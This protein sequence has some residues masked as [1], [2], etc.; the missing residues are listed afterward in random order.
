MSFLKCS[1]KGSG[2]TKSNQIISLTKGVHM[3][4]SF[5][6]SVKSAAVLMGIAGVLVF[7]GGA[8]AQTATAVATTTGLT[9]LRVGKPVGNAAK[10]TVQVSGDNGATPVVDF[11]FVDNI[12]TGD[13]TTNLGTVVPGLRLG[14][15]ALSQDKKKVDITIT[16]CPTTENANAGTLT[17]SVNSGKITAA[18]TPTVGATTATTTKAPYSAVMP[19]VAITENSGAATPTYGTATATTGVQYTLK[20]P[21]DLMVTGKPITLTIKDSP[22]PEGLNVYYAASGN[23]TSKNAAASFSGSGELI[24]FTT[25][26]K[27]PVLKDD[28]VTVTVGGQGMETATDVEVTLA[29]TPLAVSI[30][31]TTNKGITSVVGPDG[32]AGG[33]SYNGSVVYSGQTSE[34]NVFTWKQVAGL[35]AFE[36]GNDAKVVYYTTVTGGNPPSGGDDMVTDGSGADHNLPVNVA[37]EYHAFLEVTGYGNYANASVYLGKFAITKASPKVTW[38]TYNATVYDPKKQTL[39]DWDISTGDDGKDGDHINDAGSVTGVGDDGDLTGTFAWDNEDN[40]V[41]VGTT[42]YTAKWTPTTGDLGANNYKIAWNAKSGVSADANNVIDKT[43]GLTFKLSK[44]DLEVENIAVKGEW[45]TAEQASITQ[46]GV[47]DIWEGSAIW[48]TYNAAGQKVIFAWV[49]QEDDDDNT[50]AGAK[51]PAYQGARTGTTTKDTLVLTVGYTGTTLAGKSFGTATNPSTTAPTEAGVYTVWVK[52]GTSGNYNG[53]WVTGDDDEWTLVILPRLIEAKTIEHFKVYDATIDVL[54]PANVTLT[55]NTGGSTKNDKDKKVMGTTKLKAVVKDA[56]YSNI[57]AGTLEIN[58]FEVD[59]GNTNYQI[60]LEDKYE[61]PDG[62]IESSHDA[63]EDCITKYVERGTKAA[64][65]G[66]RQAPITIA[67]SG[68]T[69]IEKIFNGDSTADVAVGSEEEEGTAIAFDGLQGDDELVYGVDYE[70]T[71]P[72]Y[73]SKNVGEDIPV[74]SGRL[75]LYPNGT[76]ANLGHTAAWNYKFAKAADSALAGKGI[77]GTIVPRELGVSG[78]FE[79]AFGT[80]MKNGKQYTGSEIVL[81]DTVGKITKAELYVSDVPVTLN[82][83][84]GNK[85][86][87]I[88][89]ND[90]VLE[91]EDNLNVTKE[92]KVYIH[93]KEGGNYKDPELTEIEALEFEIVPR[94]LTLATKDHVV[95]RRYYHEGDKSVPI[96]SLNFVGLVAG[97]KLTLE[98]EDED[99]DYKLDGVE[100]ATADAS[101]D[102]KAV[103]RGTIELTSS[104]LAA[105]YVLDSKVK[106]SSAG[107]KGYVDKMPLR[108]T[109]VETGG[110]RVYNGSDSVNIVNI[111]FANVEQEDDEEFDIGSRNAS[112]GYTVSGAKYESAEVGTYSSIAAGTVALKGSSNV[113]N[114]IINDPSLAGKGDIDDEITQRNLSI[115]SATVS[116]AFD[117][118]ATINPDDVVLNFAS[119]SGDEGLITADKGKE[120]YVVEGAAFADEAIKSGKDIASGTITL[121]DYLARNYSLD[122]GD[123]ASFK[124]SITKG[125]IPFIVTHTKV[126]D[127]GVAAAGAEYTVDPGSHPLWVGDVMELLKPVTWTYVTKNAGETKVK[128]GAI[129][130]IATLPK[131][132][133]D[134][135]QFSQ[136]PVDM[137]TG[138]ITKKPLPI[139]TVTH[140]KSYDGTTDAKITNISF[141]SATN[142]GL[143]STDAASTVVADT[144]EAE[145]T[146]PSVGTTTVLIKKV[147]L[148]GTNG[149]NYQV[150]I[151]D[152]ALTVGGT[153][154]GI[155]GATATIAKVTATK[156]YD[157]TNILDPQYVEVSFNGIAAVDTPFVDYDVSGVTL[158]DKN[159]GTK[160]ISAGKVELINA[161]LENYIFPAASG[162][163]GGGRYTVTVAPKTLKILSAEHKKDYDGTTA[164]KNVKVELD[165]SGLVGTDTAANVTSVEAQY[166]SAALGTK[167][168]KITKITVAGGNYTADTA[169]I[170]LADGGITGTYVD[171][172]TVTSAVAGDSVNGRRSVQLTANVF[173]TTASIR[174]VAW[175]VSDTALATVNEKTGLL[176]SK[177]NGTVVVTAASTDGSGKKGTLTLKIYGVGVLEAEREIPTQVVISEAA[178]A[179][180]KAVVAKFTAGP[181]PAKVGSSIKFFSGSAVKSG[182]L[183]IFDASGNAVAKVAAKAGSGEIGAWNLKG[184]NGAV[185]SEG[186]YIVKGA[187]VGKD[188]TREKVSFVFSVVK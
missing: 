29:I 99:G 174:A 125:V 179:P 63:G 1:K 118:T 25:S 77:T 116:K 183:Y 72:Y 64:P 53:N 136:D 176:T 141:P 108:I 71:K 151:P 48:R 17:V 52:T 110:T 106:L 156:T 36:D 21:S 188:G 62:P 129:S 134:I 102:L 165:L 49:P 32:K 168:L 127:G 98:T 34:K 130:P 171:S 5:F 162:N 67:V 47:D 26:A 65:G 144:I 28:K 113:K 133:T 181:S 124:G 173:P 184:K 103:S 8:A 78:E 148:K 11:V 109:A 93:A 45:R 94:T 82:D 147:T 159:A 12:A 157:G 74:I 155:V 20:I 31:T 89:K 180:V 24:R 126:Y 38:P 143:V 149:G 76:K 2:F 185:V 88:T 83:K 137:G 95:S 30:G 81:K 128:P 112:L 46:L 120:G 139:A 104:D 177:K 154:A 123:L 4:L 50:T 13:F 27:T 160:L 122:N 70:L 84:S 119:A 58:I 56:V 161:A 140:S 97:D 100:Y 167:T 152:T 73:K 142:G 170:T 61:L 6:K 158:V 163:L 86:N 187:L 18:T 172:I 42:V 114:Y 186:T 35:S 60:Y 16:G 44:K 87:I 39:A 10:L 101:D 105:N 96:V 37:T 117:G 153:P 146:S 57:D 51:G 132:L 43:T 9:S 115:K 22:K 169:T 68:H 80:A 14:A 107:I 145:Y 79:F 3:T 135:Y 111:T 55:F 19:G 54:D 69:M 41:S 75:S 59:L 23:A 85:K 175:S 166:T 138:G 121:T 15:L 178:V 131:E 90:Y 182:S 91:Y 40:V 92:A 150:V 66:I 7:G 33:A 164:A